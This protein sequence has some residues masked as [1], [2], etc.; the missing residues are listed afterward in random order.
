MY[1]ALRVADDQTPAQNIHCIGDRANHVVLNIFEDILSNSEH[2]SA[3]E[4]RPRIE[5]AQIMTLDDLERVG[6]LQGVSCSSFLVIGK[7][8][9]KQ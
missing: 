9:Y 7:L 1:R 4:R 6:R 5:H 3:T 2:G 8:K